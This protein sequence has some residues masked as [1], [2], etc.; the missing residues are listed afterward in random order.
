M[1]CAFTHMARFA[2]ADGFLLQGRRKASRATHA[3]KAIQVKILLE[4]LKSSS[5]KITS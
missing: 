3:C 1:G 5:N 2:N 4:T